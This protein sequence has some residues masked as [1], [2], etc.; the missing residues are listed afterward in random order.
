MLSNLALRICPLTGVKQES[1][2]YST[3]KGEIMQSENKL[4]NKRRKKLAFWLLVIGVSLAVI[5]IC[6]WDIGR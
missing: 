4:E 2:P 6:L 3:Y 1:R 5:I